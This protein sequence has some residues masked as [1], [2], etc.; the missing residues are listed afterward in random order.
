M[1]HLGYP[2]RSA[3]GALVLSHRPGRA[4]MIHAIMYTNIVNHQRQE[5]Y[6]TPGPVGLTSQQLRELPSFNRRRAALLTSGVRDLPVVGVPVSLTSSHIAQGTNVNIVLST[7][8]AIKRVRIQMLKSDA[9]LPKCK[10]G[11]CN[12]KAHYSTGGDDVTVCATHRK[13]H[14]VRVYALTHSRHICHCGTRATYGV[15][16]QAPKFCYWHKTPDSTTRFNFQRFSMHHR[17][18][19]VGSYVVPKDSDQS[20]I[21]LLKAGIEPNPGP[22][23]ARDGWKPKPVGDKPK[24]YK[25]AEGP[26]VKQPGKA[27]VNKNVNR[28][29][30]LVEEAVMDNR[31]KEQADPVK[32]L[33][34]EAKRLKDMND[35]LV[36]KQEEEIRSHFIDALAQT[37]NYKC[38]VK[39][40]SS[41]QAFL[42][43]EA[44]NKA[45]TFVADTLLIKAKTDSNAA[46]LVNL[47]GRSK[48]DVERTLIAPRAEIE[49][50]KVAIEHF[51]VQQQKDR[52]NKEEDIKKDEVE[53]LHS[54]SL[55]AAESKKAAVQIE[56]FKARRQLKETALQEAPY[57]GYN[58][59]LS[60][61]FRFKYKEHEFHYDLRPSIALMLSLL[62]FTFA[63]VIGVWGIILLLLSMVVVDLAV[64]VFFQIYDPSL[65]Y[66]SGSKY[67]YTS[68]NGYIT[69]PGKPLL[70]ELDVR[71]ENDRRDLVKYEGL[72]RYFDV[73]HSYVAPVKL[74]TY[75]IPWLK[76]HYE[77][78][79]VIAVSMGLL[80]QVITKRVSYCDEESWVRSKIEYNM[81]N[82]T[83]VNVDKELMY[84]PH[85]DSARPHGFAVFQ[86]TVDVAW[87]WFMSQKQMNQ[88]V[89]RPRAVVSQPK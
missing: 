15:G 59:F 56:A 24:A 44:E 79:T 73:K 80:Q 19:F 7:K 3:V 85:P 60:E 65:R 49:Q 89:P 88:H 77:I 42:I 57:D 12:A 39:T 10:I 37:M 17:G 55:E 84:L 82:M 30:K 47:L 1:D 11:N 78:N 43:A 62:V 41:E 13:A 67:T 70:T 86:Q 36:A 48:L 87:G 26:I 45:A 5:E 71:M 74:L 20:E 4:S 61:G 68:R 58:F 83:N 75:E 27:K 6:P 76:R 29:I 22:P 34:L 46:S 25:K 64:I 31:A 23:K 2:R 53:A 50:N 52:V 28:E 66:S 32:D 54:V 35:A 38:D 72:V 33:Q 63:W 69:V 14:H 51:K 16:S 8:S 18:Q 21:E 40:L 9:H 81:S